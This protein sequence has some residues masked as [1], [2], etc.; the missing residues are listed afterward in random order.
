M[1]TLHLGEKQ[2]TVLFPEHRTL[3][4]MWIFGQMKKVWNGIVSNCIRFVMNILR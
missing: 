3:L 2:V 4:D 1:L